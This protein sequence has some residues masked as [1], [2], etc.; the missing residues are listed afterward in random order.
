MSL[1]IS[2]Q[3]HQQ[4]NQVHFIIPLVVEGGGD[5]LICIYSIVTAIKIARFAEIRLLNFT[6]G[7][8]YE[9]CHSHK[10]AISKHRL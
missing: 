10:L 2:V 8:V 6:R 7:E 5:L 3:L 9:K 1:Y 4:K